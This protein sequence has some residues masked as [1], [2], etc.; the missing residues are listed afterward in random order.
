MHHCS[1]LKKSRNQWKTKAKERGGAMRDLRK[2]LGRFRRIVEERQT[3]LEDRILRLEAENSALRSSAAVSPGGLPILRQPQA[4][5]RTLCVLL[6]IQG[7]ISFRSVPRIM[8]IFQCMGRAAPECIPHFTSVIHWTLRAGVAIIQGVSN[9]EEPWIAIIDCSIDIGTRKALVVL[10][11]T[12]AALSR[13][14]SAI[15]LDDCECIG[16]EVSN[17]W[18]GSTVQDALK[19]IFDQAGQPK[20]ILMDGGKDLQ[21]GVRLYREQEDAKRIAVIEDVGHT[22][23][24]ALKAEFATSTPFTTFL[25]ILRK[26]AARIRQTNLAALLPPK[27]RT[28]GRFQGITEVAGWALKILELI[29]GQGRAEESGDLSRLRKAF[30]GLAQLRSFLL[31]FCGTCQTIE[32]FLKLTKNH[33]IN[34][35]RFAEAQKLLEQLPGRSQTRNR[36]EAWLARQLRIQCMLG[37]GQL[38][39]L[40]SSDVI[41]SLFGKFKV[42][43]QRNPCAELNR[44]VYVIPLLCGQHTADEIDTALSNCSHQ[45]MLAKIADKIPPTL[46]QL[47]HR[48]LNPAWKRVPKSGNPRRFTAG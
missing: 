28:K 8:A 43:V 33:G 6:I 9:V 14:G 44:L 3:K 22:A 11:V 39:L 7:I 20:A 36:M 34:Q 12:L 42:I 25:D 41:E 23:A 26:G 10:R 16:L 19:R 17:R 40:V 38:P 13:K 1:R 29:G 27:V 32:Q 21:K 2:R 30:S 24:N 35:A 37:I 5:R 46:R 18:I 15:G 45:Q 4:D 47:R 48:M 31:R